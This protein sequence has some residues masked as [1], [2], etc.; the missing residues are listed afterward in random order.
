MTLHRASVFLGTALTGGSHLLRPPPAGSKSAPLAVAGGRRWPK[1]M[2]L[3]ATART[4]SM[5]S[6]G[7]VVGCGC[8]RCA[9]R[10]AGTARGVSCRA[11]CD[12]VGV[13]PVDQVVD[14]RLQVRSFMVSPLAADVPRLQIVAEQGFLFA[15]VNHV[16]R[17]KM[18]AYMDA[19]WLIKHLLDLRAW[20]RLM[21]LVGS[22]R[23]T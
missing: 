13:V 19:W 7:G 4:L 10:L 23:R 18:H 8:G 20:S 9:A 1:S 5:C 22:W 17:Y 14:Q 12:L 11:A 15:C 6:G 3:M 16:I 21:A 2:R